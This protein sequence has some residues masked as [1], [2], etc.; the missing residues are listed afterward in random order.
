MKPEERAAVDRLR[1]RLLPHYQCQNED[2][3]RL[4]V[5]LGVDNESLRLADQMHIDK[6][7]LLILSM[8][9]PVDF[10]SLIATRDKKEID[11][12]CFDLLFQH[13]GASVTLDFLRG[14]ESD[15]REDLIDGILCGMG[16]GDLDV[17]LEIMLDCDDCSKGFRGEP[18]VRRLEM[19]S[20]DNWRTYRA[21]PIKSRRRGADIEAIKN[22]IVLFARDNQP[23]TVRQT[24]YHL[25][26][27][28]FVRKDEGEYDQT[29]VRLMTDMRRDGELPYEWIADNTRW[30]RQPRTF[31]SVE[32]A[33]EETKRTYRRSV[34]RDLPVNVEI[35]C[36][37][38]ALAGVI[39][40][41]T[42]PY[43][44][45]LMVSRGFSSDSYLH[46][47]A[48]QIQLSGKPT[49]VY[50]FGDHDPAGTKIDEDL[51]KRL[52]AFVPLA[53]I[54]FERVAVTPDLI[55]EMNLPTRPTK[56][57]HMNKKFE[58]DSVDLDA[59]PPLELRRLVRECI[60]RHIPEGHLD[61]LEA[62]ESSEREILLSMRLPTAN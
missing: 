59:I 5:R 25:V 7:V 10:A 14:E 26:S 51:E 27:I 23:V 18:L 29:V 44:V 2:I 41:E 47:V 16:D 49:Y 53:E 48:E 3:L 6:K 54:H 42:D 52:R 38:D 1:E 61:A 22:A 30:I 57:Q 50:Y 36:E 4:F 35:W 11:S 60:E 32:E 62:A 46:Q 55:E 15:V 12:R 39:M 13:N 43:D 8:L 24:F 9:H 56:G 19:A 37:K 20:E 58:G 40:Q 45:P 17:G 31:D 33:L 34:W 28:G 21:S